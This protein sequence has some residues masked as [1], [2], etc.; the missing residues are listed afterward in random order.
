[1]RSRTVGA[2]GDPGGH[3]WGTFAK[4]KVTLARQGRRPRRPHAQCGR[5]LEQ[6]G[7]PWPPALGQHDQQQAHLISNYRPAICGIPAKDYALRRI[8][9]VQEPI[10]KEA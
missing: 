4:P 3:R 9:G 1:M 7:H 10:V 8:N 6:P 2:A 5:R